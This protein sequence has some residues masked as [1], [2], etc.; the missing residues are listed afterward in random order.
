[1]VFQE[2]ASKQEFKYKF[3]KEYIVLINNRKID[4]CRDLTPDFI[5]L[6]WLE[7]LPPDPNLCRNLGF[8]F[9]KGFLYSHCKTSQVL[10]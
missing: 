6:W 7:N 10:A 5:S 3:A 4:N 2:V 9:D 1:M 8:S